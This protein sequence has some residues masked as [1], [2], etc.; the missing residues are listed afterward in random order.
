MILTFTVVDYV[1]HKTKYKYGETV[2]ASIWWLEKIF[3]VTRAIIA[4]VLIIGFTH[5]E[6]RVP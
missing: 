1:A 5:L 6:F 3:P 4:A 2:S